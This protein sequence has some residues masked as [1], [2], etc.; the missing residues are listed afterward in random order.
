MENISKYLNADG[1]ISARKV[2]RSVSSRRTRKEGTKCCRRPGATKALKPMSGV[3]IKQ[4][5]R[6]VEK[7]RLETILAA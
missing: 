2:R 7:L 5:R 6:F 3:V 4:K 1:T